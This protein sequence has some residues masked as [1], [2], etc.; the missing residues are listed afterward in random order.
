[1]EGV[2]SL[3]SAVRD[4]TTAARRHLAAARRRDPETRRRVRGIAARLALLTWVLA[5][6]LLRLDH[7]GRIP[8][9]QPRVRALPERLGDADEPHLASVLAHAA[10]VVQWQLVRPGARADR[11]ERLVADYLER[12]GEDLARMGKVLAR[13]S[14]AT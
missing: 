14:A 11:V 2:M 4:L 9:Q 12:A 6:D 13:R 7:D 8:R 3:E 1:M 10:E 5:A